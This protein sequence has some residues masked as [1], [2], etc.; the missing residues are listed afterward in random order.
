MDIT[1]KEKTEIV[2]AGLET[3]EYQQTYDTKAR[4]NGNNHHSH[5]LLLPVITLETLLSLV[6]AD[7]QMLLMA[8]TIERICK[9]KLYCQIKLC[10]VNQRTYC[11]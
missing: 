2:T 4:V 10:Q 7:V 5:I 9:F 3:T 11:I 6:I 1:D 8:I